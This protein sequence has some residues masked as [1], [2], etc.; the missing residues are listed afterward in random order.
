M[1]TRRDFLKKAGLL[2]G[3]LGVM[4]SLPASI[5]RALTINP[6]E[7]STYHD[8][9]HIVLLMQENRSFDHCFGALKGVRGFNDPRSISL[10]NKN[11]VW[12]Q[13]N[14][15]GETFVPFRLDIKETKA[16][17][18]GGLP[19]SWEDQVDA[20]NNGRYDNWLEA[21]KVYRKPYRHIPLTMGYHNR[22]DIPFYYAFADAFTVFD[23]HFCSSLT[24]TTTNR[25]FF[26]SGK[27]RETPTSKSCVRNSDIYYNK[28]VSWKTFPER[29]EENGISWRIYQ[30]EISLQTELKG[31]DES[32]LSNFTDNNLEWFSQYN[33]RYSKGHQDF[34]KKRFAELPK[35]IKALKKAI[36]KKPK[37]SIQKLKN[38]LEQ[39]QSQLEKIQKELDLWSPE[40]Y[41]KLSEFKKRIHN[42]AF[43]TNSND[44]HYHETETIA[45]KDG[46]EERSIKVPKGDI[47]HQF[48]EDVSKGKLPTVSWLVAPQ[49]FSDHPSAPWFGA[50][51]VSEV[52]DILTKNPEVWKKTI[53]ILTYDE[54]DGY[55]D[56]I[57]PFV[58]PHPKQKNKTSKNIDA[59]SEYVTLE[60]ELKKDDIKPEN[61]R[62]SAVGLG[63]RVPMIIASPWTRGGWVNSEVCDLTST[64]QFMETFLS[65]KIGK[66]IKE[67]NISSWRRA[68]TGDLTT[69][70]HP[71]QSSTFNFSEFI[72]RNSFV[73]ELYK[74]NFKAP[75]S[76]F[77]PLT[78]E[79][80]I[81]ARVGK[82]KLEFMP[83]QESGIKNSCALPY[84]LYVHDTL[85]KNKGLFQLTFKA[86]KSF[87]GEK[88]SGA[89]FTVYAPDDYLQEVALG[90]QKFL[91]FKTWD[92]A[93]EAGERVIDTWPINH[94]KGNQYHL[95]IYGPNGFFRKYKG[96]LADPE[97]EFRCHYEETGRYLKKLSGNVELEVI[98]NSLLDYTIELV[99]HAYN[100][101]KK[102][103]RIAVGSTNQ[104]VLKSSASYGWYDFSVRIKGE[105]SFERRFA[106]RVETGKPSKTDPFMGMEQ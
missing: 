2:T 33:V 101:P 47:L 3:G 54:N 13:S 97:L 56:H 21:K 1:N 68:I 92:F 66:P 50:W 10:P 37:R 15:K 45:F 93:V 40:N 59:A 98:N 51:Y 43:T 62:E 86:S 26:W 87:F 78:K 106:G 102:D 27:A 18:M 103:Y 81:K 30:N 36:K 95:C 11:P 90:E 99:D 52:L 79:Q 6:E 65:N 73:Q 100:N 5:Q 82:S 31:E 17:W 63:Y 85:N 4:G 20:R 44:P 35:E 88:S 104:I 12:L 29:L 105:E 46:K 69:A 70:F 72:D 9:E 74:A 19:H 53:F 23:Q 48:R 14:K 89:P 83:K 84:E 77:K 49:K 8:A 24:G 80:L 16:T 71:F 96:G 39:K 58:A 55:F 91:P 94:F 76:N 38:K 25:Q 60:E 57:P 32:L 42:R 64:L 22:A 34:L 28:E 7:G 75:P 41:N 61:A 67:T